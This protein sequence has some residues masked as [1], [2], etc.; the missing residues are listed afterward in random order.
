MATLIRRFIVSSNEYIGLVPIDTEV[1]DV[2]CVLFGCPMPVIMR[3][4]EDYYIFISE[5]YIHGWMDGEAMKRHE[6]GELEKMTFE[7]R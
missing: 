5:A 6:S 3:P 2:I 4:V 1:E 7:I